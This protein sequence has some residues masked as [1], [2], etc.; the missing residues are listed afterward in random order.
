MGAER[1]FHPGRLATGHVLSGTPGNGGRWRSDVAVTLSATDT[2]SGG[3]GTYY[4][5]V[6]ITARVQPEIL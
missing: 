1:R 4:R 5:A 6:G 3:A 2:G